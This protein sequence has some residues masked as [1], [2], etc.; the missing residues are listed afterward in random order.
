MFHTLNCISNKYFAF[1]YISIVILYI[2]SSPNLRRNNFPQECFL[3]AGS[4]LPL[5]K[6]QYRFKSLNY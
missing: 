4:K 1:Y 2:L 5:N 6:Y 3:E